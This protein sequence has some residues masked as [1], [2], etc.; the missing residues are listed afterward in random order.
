MPLPSWA[1]VGGNARRRWPP[2]WPQPIPPERAGL[3]VGTEKRGPGAGGCPGGG[4]VQGSS[5][6]HLVPAELLPD[7]RVQLRVP[8]AIGGVEQVGVQVSF[9]VLS[10]GS[11]TGVCE[12]ERPAKAPRWGPGCVHQDPDA[13]SSLKGIG[14]QPLGIS[15]SSCRTFREPGGLIWPTAP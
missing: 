4:R 7:G 9:C 14:D 15:A 11:Q 1:Q 8:G 3:R 10:H 5:G 13:P 6:T 2:W 12:A